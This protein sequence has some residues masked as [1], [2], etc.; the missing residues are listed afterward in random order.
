MMVLVGVLLPAR[1]LSTPEGAVEKTPSAQVPMDLEILCRTWELEQL[2][3]KHAEFWKTARATLAL[4]VSNRD[5]GYADE[6]LF[7]LAVMG[8]QIFLDDREYDRFE[9][10]AFKA[11]LKRPYTEF[12][13][14]AVEKEFEKLIRHFTRVSEEFGGLNRDVLKVMQAKGALSSVAD[15]SQVCK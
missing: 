9:L 7:I 1:V 2:Y 10:S 5:T 14:L 8:V 12:R 3:K 13:Y 6:N 4:L 11:E 15:L